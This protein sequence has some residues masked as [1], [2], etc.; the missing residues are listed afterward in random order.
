MELIGNGAPEGA[1]SSVLP[2]Y[3]RTEV[4]GMV[5]RVVK[6]MSRGNRVER[7][8][9]RIGT[10]EGVGEKRLEGFEGCVIPMKRGTRCGAHGTALDNPP[11]KVCLC[12]AQHCRVL[13]FIGAISEW[14]WSWIW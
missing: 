9:C 14:V 3:R 13:F 6:R 2:F 11:S 1:C 10:V 12:S 4:W 7:R 8:L 5:V